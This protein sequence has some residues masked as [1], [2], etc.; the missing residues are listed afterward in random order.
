MSG[1]WLAAG[2][3]VAVAGWATAA[4]IAV[5]AA[6]STV[7]YLLWGDS[8][9]CPL[10]VG[11]TDA[12]AWTGYRQCRTRDCRRHRM[13]AYAGGRDR[14]S[15][16]ELWAHEVDWRARPKR[17]PAIR[18]RHRVTYLTVPFRPLALRVER[19][20][21]RRYHPQWNTQHVPA[22]VR[23]PRWPA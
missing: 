21:I 6:N 14:S 15:R 10:R 7:V 9:R 1:W 23:A 11:I 20:L 19:R 8:W 2:V 17:W 13:C 4:A 12:D 18:R 5:A 16:S 22:H 3:A